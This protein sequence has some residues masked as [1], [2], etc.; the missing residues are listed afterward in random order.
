[1]VWTGKVKIN[2]VG[3]SLVYGLHFE[4][5]E[6]FEDCV[7]ELIQNQLPDNIDREDHLCYVGTLSTLLWVNQKEYLKSPP[8]EIVIQQ[9]PGGSFKTWVH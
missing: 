8:N 4:A 1:M 2:G 9:K 3:I 7:D 6:K 5:S